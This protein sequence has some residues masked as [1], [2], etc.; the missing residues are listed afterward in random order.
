[1][2]IVPRRSRVERTVLPDP[3]PL[4]MQGAVGCRCTLAAAR[5]GYFGTRRDVAQQSSIA[6]IVEVTGQE[7]GD[8]SG[9]DMA[10]V[11]SRRESQTPRLQP[12][13]RSYV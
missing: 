10:L 8:M 11:F 13:A 6:I 4:H 12:P 2:T 5:E 9:G 7:D 1:M 3:Q